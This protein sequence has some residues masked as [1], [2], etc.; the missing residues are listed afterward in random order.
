MRR[1]IFNTSILGVAVVTLSCGGASDKKQATVV[2]VEDYETSTFTVAAGDGEVSG[3]LGNVTQD[4][5][6]RTFSDHQNAMMRCYEDAIADLEEIEGEVRFEAEVASDGTVN[7]AFISASDLGSIE[8]ESCM[9]N[10]LRSFNFKR[11]P[12]G[13]AV[14]YYPLV[15]EA[16]YDHPAFADWPQSEIDKVVSE[17]RDALNRCLGGASGVRLTV[18]IGMGGVVLSAG[19]SAETLDAYETVSCISNEARSW[20]FPNPGD[21]IV[22]VF[23]DL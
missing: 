12:G 10:H 19:A 11:V 21:R 14:I 22:K 7:S 5:I 9:V 4:E 17:H 18:Y 2:S 1:N 16:P 20:T 13:V 6:E 8:T 23:V 3:L 15:L